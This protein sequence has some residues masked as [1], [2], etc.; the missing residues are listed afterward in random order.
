M[1]KRL[2]FIIKQTSYR[3]LL[4]ILYIF[5]AIKDE[6]GLAGRYNSL[7]TRLDIVIAVVG[8]YLLFAYG[9]KG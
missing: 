6:D 9:F 4:E 7:I 3:M 2:H 5:K 1:L 8:I